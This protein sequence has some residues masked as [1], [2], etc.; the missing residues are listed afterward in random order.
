[1]NKKTRS[2]SEMVETKCIATTGWTAKGSE[3]AP[4]HLL[5]RLGAAV[6]WCRW[7][8]RGKCRKA[9]QRSQWQDFKEMTLKPAEFKF[10]LKEHL[11]WTF[12]ERPSLALSLAHKGNES[13][14]CRVQWYSAVLNTHSN[15]KPLIASNRTADEQETV[16]V[17]LLFLLLL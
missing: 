13:F 2:A 5:C 15:K 4:Q 16:S 9:Q 10:L 1:M 14:P 7:T 11:L 6:Q 3:T 17:K 8:P 12:R